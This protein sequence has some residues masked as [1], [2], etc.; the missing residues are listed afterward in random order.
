MEIVLVLVAARF[1]HGVPN[2]R[3]NPKC[4][5]GQAAAVVAQGANLLKFLPECAVKLQGC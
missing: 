1:A 3:R 5:G 2:W 4:Q